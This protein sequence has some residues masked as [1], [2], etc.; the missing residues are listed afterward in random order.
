MQR[1]TFG[2]TMKCLQNKGFCSLPL[3]HSVQRFHGARWFAVK[4]LV[5][6]VEQLDS[7]KAPMVLWSNASARKRGLAHPRTRVC[8]LGR[9]KGKRENSKRCPSQL[10]VV[11]PALGLGGYGVWVLPP[12]GLHGDLKQTTPASADCRLC[13]PSPGQ[14]VQWQ[15][16]HC[17]RDCGTWKGLWLQS[18]L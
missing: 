18:A 17:L 3:S 12:V 14:K 10:E 11:Y 15:L 5:G 1:C 9:A 4:V 6:G 7:E 13:V 16:L 2:K 8:W